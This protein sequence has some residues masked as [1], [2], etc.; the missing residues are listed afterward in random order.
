LG[1]EYNFPDGSNQGWYVDAGYDIQQHL[2]LKHRTTLNVRYDEY[3]RNKGNESREANWSIW[4]LTGEYFFHKQA[5]ARLTYQWLDVNVD[6]RTG[7]SGTNGNA[8]LK[9][10]NQ[11]LGLQLTLFFSHIPAQ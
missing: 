11:R 3:D 10:I 5:R 8:L 6:N 7:T 4:S 1:S 9:G 2:G